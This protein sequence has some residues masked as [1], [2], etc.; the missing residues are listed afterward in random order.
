MDNKEK[1]KGSWRKNEN[2]N[3]YLENTI[4]DNVKKYVLNIL[5]NQSEE[6]NSN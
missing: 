1:Y 5:P 3:W 2:G 6:N 4:L